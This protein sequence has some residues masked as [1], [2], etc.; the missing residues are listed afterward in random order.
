MWSITCCASLSWATTTGWSRPPWTSAGG[1]PSPWDETPAGPGVLRA[2][3]RGHGRRG[4]RLLL[5]C[6]FDWKIDA[7]ING[8]RDQGP[9]RTEVGQPGPGSCLVAG[10]PGE[11]GRIQGSDFAEGWQERVSTESVRRLSGGISEIATS[12]S[13]CSR[14][15]SSGSTFECAAPRS[16][17][18]ADPRATTGSCRP[19]IGPGRC[20]K[21]SS[22]TIF[23][24]ICV[25]IF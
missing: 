25:A 21:S 15:G 22:A 24:E 17:V 4:D 13:V 16:A 18:C 14:T 6:L 20:G 9:G 7:D 10:Q 19:W 5:R 3:D 11:E 1:P 23:D 2:H 12:C 8:P